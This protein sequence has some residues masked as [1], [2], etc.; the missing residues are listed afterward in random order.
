MKKTVQKYL[1]L[2][3]GRDRGTVAVTFFLSLPIFLFIISLMA[4]YALIIN[5]RI[6]LGHATA[7]AARSAMVA[8]P[9][10]PLVDTVYDP[11]SGSSDGSLDGVAFVNRAARMELESISPKALG[12]NSTEATSVA[13]ALQASGLPIPDSFADHYTFA[14]N[15]TTI[16]WQRLDDSDQHIPETQ[17][18]P[19][20]FAKAPGQRIQL[21]IH[22]YF[23]LNAPG[24]KVW[25]PLIG[26]LNPPALQSAFND[27]RDRYFLPMTSTYIVQL[28]HG[29]ET[30]A[31]SNGVPFQ[32]AAP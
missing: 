8:L 28:S 1:Q 15:A 21:T 24:V 20:D 18:Q 6:V 7:A 30:M 10:D 2:L 27:G 16:E 22:Y 32:P 4:Q 14:E 17:W 13:Q 19:A 25:G 11:N 31:D 23:Y 26:E 3:R 9:T 29:R 12:G 5:A